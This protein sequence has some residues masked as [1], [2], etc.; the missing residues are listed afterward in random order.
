M[1]QLDVS[2]AFLHGELNE[3]VY[4]RQPRGFEHP[5]Y[6]QHVCKLSRAIYGLKQSPRVWFTRL[7]TYLLD[8]GFKQS[9]SDHSMFI[10]RQDG[11]IFILLIYVDDIVIFGSSKML[12]S[13]F[14]AS[15]KS[16]F[17]MKDLGSL[18]YFLGVEIV[19]NTDGVLLLQRQYISNL[20][21][22]FDLAEVKPVQPPLYSKLDWHSVATPLL[23]DSSMYRQM[24]RSLQYLSFT[25]TDI[26]YAVNM[27]SQFLHQPRLIHIQAVK[28]IFRYLKGTP[29]HGLQLYRNS[30]ISLTIFSDS[31][32]AGCTATHRSTSGFCTLLGNNLI[33]W[34]TMKQPTVSRSSTEAKYRALTVA[35]ADATWLQFLL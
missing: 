27:A 6:P 3:V 28:R 16:E 9:T 35:T 26:Q 19:H 18:H 1:H 31:D 30:S 11:A 15:M 33:S 24:V 10:F 13:E 34:S 4:M 5:D 7:A 2:N 17:A 20:L 14:I 32:W 12:V 8:L 23:D 25:R 29:A 22:H 21:H